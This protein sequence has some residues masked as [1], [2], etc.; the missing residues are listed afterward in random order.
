MQII[1]LERVEKLGQ[2]GDVVTVKPGYARNF[3]LPKNKALRAT[4]ANLEVFETQR[5]QLEA[6]NLKRKDEAT[7]VAGKL[8]GLKVI[9]IRQAGESGQ[10]YGSVSAR[11]IAE[12]VTA[13][14]FTVNRA[15]VRL[16]TVIK[17]LGL[18]DVQIALHPEVLVSVTVNAARSAEEAEIQAE[19]GE[20][21]VARDDEPTFEREV[22]PIGE[23][24][25][26]DLSAETSEAPAS[27]EE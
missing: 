18:H 23:D 16:N 26:N 13:E 19:S 20:A 1:L 21:L 2:I 14:G 27:E 8:E 12:A 22:G 17:T 3:L 6:D 5:A 25:E 4:K 24:D 9:V 15:Q 7:A 10:L 11:D